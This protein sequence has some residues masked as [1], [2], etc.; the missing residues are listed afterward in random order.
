MVAFAGETGAR[1]IAEGVEDPA[2]RDTLLARG[3][4]YGQGYLFG[5]PRPAREVLGAA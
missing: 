4:R 5:R 2:E 3:V 1:L